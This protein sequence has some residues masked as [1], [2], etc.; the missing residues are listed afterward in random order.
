[1]GVKMTYSV[2]IAGNGETSR[3][4]VEALMADH[5]YA[6]GEGGTLVIA[7]NQ[8]P[9]QGQVWAAQLANQQKLDVVVF[10]KSGA[11]LDSISHA[12][13]SESDSPFN[14]AMTSF[15]DKNAQAFLLWSDED[16]DCLD[17]LASAKGAEIPAYDLCDG[18]AAITPVE[19][20]KPSVKTPEMP[21]VENSTK[22]AEEEEYDEDEEEID[23]D[24]EDYEEAV[25]EIYAGIEALVEMIADRVVAKLGETKTK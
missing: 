9:S 8:R 2:V 16:P 15:K 25:D 20:I 17:A 21:K 6:N 18:L 11:F 24:E 13:L 10:A 23:D 5:Y 3:A 19:D 4:N 22:S 7:F 14:D 1:M 12:T